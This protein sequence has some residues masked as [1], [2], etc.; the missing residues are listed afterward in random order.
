MSVNKHLANKFENW[1]K[2]SI[3]GYLLAN[4]SHL[5]ALDE[6]PNV[7]VG[8]KISKNHVALISGG[9]SGHEPAHL[10]FVG[11]GMLTGVVCGDLFTS[12]STHSILA[13]LRHLDT[14]NNNHGVLMIVKNYTGDR[15][16]FGLAAKRAQLE[17]INVDWVLVDDDWALYENSK[18]PE[19]TVGR[20]GLCGTVFIHK[21]AGALA[22]QGKSLQDIKSLL[23]GILKK[24]DLRTIGV[25]LSGRV[26]LPGEQV[27]DSVSN[28][29][30]EIGLGIHGESGRK[31][32]QLNSSYD[33]V[34][35]VLNEY[36]FNEIKHGEVC[37]MVNNLGGLSNLELYLLVN[38]CVKYLNQKQ[39]N[40]TI[41]RLYCGTLM[42]SLNM[43]GFSIT[44]L[45]LKDSNKKDSILS[46]L[47][48]QT[49]AP[50][51]PLLYGSDV[52]SVEHVKT[53]QKPESSYISFTSFIIKNED[54]VRFEDAKT[55]ELLK[56]T[57]KTI[58][59]DLIT[60]REV[61]NDLD[62]KCGDGDCG[63]SLAKIGE[64]ILHE[65]DS[66]QKFN[67]QYPHQVLL[68]CSNI[69]E[70]GG[71]TLCIILSLL[72]SAFIKSFQ[73]Q[74][75]AKAE[76]ND[77]CFWVR[78]W[79][80]ALE[81]GLAVVEEYSHAKPNQR[82]IVDPLTSIKLFFESYLNNK[83]TNDETQLLLKNLVDVTFKSAEATAHMR[84]RVGRASYVNASE[85][86]APDAGAKGISSIV[87]SIYKAF[88]MFNS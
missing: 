55:A 70:N 75:E 6:F 69:L 15:L 2:D 47:D 71:G 13:A 23:T 79:K 87:N 32:V 22:Q 57:L 4:N 81:N 30:I 5:A 25:S 51:W 54:Y 12:P 8:R 18:E 10:G 53:N 14:Q 59:E 38:D 36:L 49:S 44:A 68:E 65:L 58:A 45:Y 37:L 50:A 60:V 78:I 86:N 17:G 73:K 42:T 9:G 67:F 66:P 46:L 34:E 62:A 88:L 48:S 41:K 82:S 1:A 56:F 84:P 43:N 76:Q 35:S 83:S 52:K 77:L 26:S 28:K 19:N 64:T 63:S 40:I 16:N 61:L 24:K 21:L 3:N 72:L 7:I 80:N 29:E 20:R 11:E 33:L 85:I 39:P 27:A 31:K 74:H